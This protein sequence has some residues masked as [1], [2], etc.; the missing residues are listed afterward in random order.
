MPCSKQTQA[1]REP[2]LRWRQWPMSCSKIFFDLI[3]KIRSG[4]TATDLSFRPATLPRCCIPSSTW[5]A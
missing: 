2:L 5:Q 1:I 4:Q 3:L